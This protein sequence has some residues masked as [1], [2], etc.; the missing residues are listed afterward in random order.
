MDAITCLSI[1]GT[2]IQFLEFSLE[3]VSKG[4]DLYQNGQL[5]VHIEAEDAVEDLL[6]LTSNFSCKLERPLY[7]VLKPA[8][9]NELA[10]QKLCEDCGFLAKELKTKFSLLHSQKGKVWGSFRSAL[11]SVWKEKELSKFEKRLS[12]YRAQIDS[13]MINCIL[14]VALKLLRWR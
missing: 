12:E 6:S 10:L 1:A 11:L 4:L 2:A 9:Q 8:T 5:S 14:F 3:I 13:R 7:I